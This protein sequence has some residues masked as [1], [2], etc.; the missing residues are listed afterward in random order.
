VGE[1]PGLKQ[2]FREHHTFVWRVV[3]R[4]GV[5]SSA[6]DDAVQ[7]VFI[8]LHRRHAELEL[9][10]SVRGLLYGIARKVAKRQRDRAAAAPALS[11]VEPA[12]AP[13]QEAQVELREKAAV[14]REALDAMD[15]DKR[16]TFLLAVVEGMSIPEV[17][18][19]QDVNLNTAYSRLRAAK[20]Q[21]QKAI[22]RH[23]AKGGGKRVHAGS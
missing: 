17:A 21:V 20:Q 9:R 22:A 2:I 23:R 18:A 4:L 11:L 13:C 3:R 8:V 15:E 1:L 5:P 14:I 6:V 10:G 12:Q 19:A 7:E 16:I